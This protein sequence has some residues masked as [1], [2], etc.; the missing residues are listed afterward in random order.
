MYFPDFVFKNIK[1]YLFKI[2]IPKYPE[3]IWFNVK[4]FLIKRN[5]IH[6]TIYGYLTED[7]MR[8]FY[9]LNSHP[10]LVGMINEL[11]I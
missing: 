9:E 10:I 5:N 8:Y 4:S 11:N 3:H 7:E 2:Y 1:S 6:N